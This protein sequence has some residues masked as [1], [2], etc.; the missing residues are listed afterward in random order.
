[1]TDAAQILRS[2]GRHV[3]AGK[4]TAP[5]ASTAGKGWRGVMLELFP[6]GS[7]DFTAI[8]DNPGIT[9]YLNGLVD[10]YQR[11]EGRCAH[12]V[13]RPGNMI[14][15]PPG[16][17]K[18]FQYDGD[19]DCLVV[20]VAPSLLMQVA[21]TPARGDPG[22]IEILNE[23][24]TRD[25]ELQRLTL[26]LWN[27]YVTQDIASGIYAEAIGIQLAVHMLRKYSTMR[28]AAPPPSGELSQTAYERAV[29]YIEANL[30]NDLT[31]Q[32]MADELAMSASHFAHSFKLTTGIAPHRYVMERRI[33]YAKALLRETTIP[34][35][36]LS[37]R[38]GF[39]T[40]SHFCVM[41]Q[42]LTGQTPSAFR[43]RRFARTT[44]RG[45]SVR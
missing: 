26:R 5:T 8:F 40:H 29:D 23:F 39:S 20:H 44:G 9:L 19:G 41:F 32:G 35:A 7:S 34:I 36:N 33:E 45:A 28:S 18:K 11:F 24:C 2:P 22:K 31:I 6:R 37:T 25:P 15:S 17:P 3:V 42:R 43:G 27:E 13:M 38:A 14:V 30:A 12:T 1:M 16:I 21:N 4:L 10:L